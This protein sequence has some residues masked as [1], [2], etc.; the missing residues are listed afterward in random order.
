MPQKYLPSIV[1]AMLTLLGRRVSCQG[2]DQ[3]TVSYTGSKGYEGGGS[4]TPNGHGAADR[5]NRTE[6]R[7]GPAA[8]V[9]GHLSRG[10]IP[11]GCTIALVSSLPQDLFGISPWKKRRQIRRDRPC[12]HRDAAPI[13]RAGFSS[14]P[15][16]GRRGH[17]RPNGRASNPGGPEA[18]GISSRV[19]RPT[20][21][22]ETSQRK[23]RS[24]VRSGPPTCTVDRTVF[25]LWLGG[26]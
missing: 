18:R 13:M 19:T 23:V 7:E 16:L 26:L 20:S 6:T 3:P 25:E 11:G 10:G 5:Q 17:L 21:H 2:I 22:I 9:S 15:L 12:L 24:S 4:V 8:T 14:R 1:K